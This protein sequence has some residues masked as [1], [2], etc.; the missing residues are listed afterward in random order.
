VRLGVIADIHGNSVALEAVLADAEGFGVDCWWALG[1]LV[2]FGPRPV[3]VLQML[4]ELPVV[5]YVSGNTDRYVL[6][7]EQ[8]SPHETPAHAVGELELV[9]RYVAM[10]GAIGWTRGALV[11]TGSLSVLSDMPAEQRLRLPDESLLLGVHASPGRDDGQGIDSRIDAEELAQLLGDCG[12]STVV[13]GHTHD[14]TDRV[15]G[16]VRALNPGSVG[17]PRNVAHAS[18]MLIEADADGLRTQRREV[19]FDVGVVVSD[20]HACGYP[21]ASFMEAVLTGARPMVEG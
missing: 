8:P 4:A 18:W 6:T 2:L 21:T 20:L 11:Q 12:A 3:E 5:A 17:V 16:S 15:V 13:G 1:D 7:G 19:A 10:A 9:E 14:P